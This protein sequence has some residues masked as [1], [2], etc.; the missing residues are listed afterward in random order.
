ML[1][2]PSEDVTC[3]PRADGV[4]MRIAVTGRLHPP[5]LPHVSSLGF[6]LTPNTRAP[7]APEDPALPF[8]QRECFLPLLSA[9]SL[10]P[11]DIFSQPHLRALAPRPSR[12]PPTPTPDRS[13]ARTLCACVAPGTPRPKPPATGSRPSSGEVKREV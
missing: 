10:A 1:K 13:A 5:S 11:R 12:G 3:Q 6:C 7:H 4:P 9:I 8:H 2:N